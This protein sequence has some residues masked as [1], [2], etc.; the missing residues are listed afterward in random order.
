MEFVL[1]NADDITDPTDAFANAPDPGFDDSGWRTVD[2]PHDWSIE[3]AP[4]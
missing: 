3:L 1:V 4:V 2:L